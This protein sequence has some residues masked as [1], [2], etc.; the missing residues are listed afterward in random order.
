LDRA[1]AR[2]AILATEAKY[3]AFEH[4]LSETV[5]RNEMRL[6]ACCLM[7]NQL[8]L[9]P[10]PPADGELSRSMRWLTVTHPQRW[11]SHH[12]TAGTCHVD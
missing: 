6:L 1:N 3:A 12:R 10:G 8:H 7:A 2:L 11:R 5:K 9:L 4:F